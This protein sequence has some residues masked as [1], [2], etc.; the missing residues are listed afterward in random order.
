MRHQSNS[1]GLTCVGLLFRGKVIITKLCA[2]RACLHD[3]DHLVSRTRQPSNTSNTQR[4]LSITT[5]LLGPRQSSHHLRLRSL[6]VPTCHTLP[7]GFWGICN[8]N[9]CLK[10]KVCCCPFVYV[11]IYKALK[12]IPTMERNGLL[13]PE[14][15]RTCTCTGGWLGVTG[16]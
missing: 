10:A 9:V 7:D 1:M 5:G 3:M 11:D 12:T 2:E 4:T 16:Y 15:W 13:S 14:H 6:Q 8:P